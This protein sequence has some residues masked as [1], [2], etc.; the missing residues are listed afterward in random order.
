MTNPSSF[1][2]I[3]LDIGGTKTSVVFSTTW[4]KNGET[5]NLVTQGANLQIHGATHVAGL[6][7]S[8]VARIRHQFD[9]EM[10]AVVVAGIAGAGRADDHLEV[11]QLFR[12]ALYRND[13]IMVCSDAF[14]AL[15]G[16]FS[17]GSGVIIIAGTGSGVYALDK[18]RK[19]RRAGGWGPHLG[20][21]G[22]GTSIG[23]NAL[24]SVARAF[25]GGQPTELT[26][27][28]AEHFGIYD[29]SDLI[30]IVYREGFYPATCAPLVIQSAE[31]GDAV[32]SEMVLMEIK[33]LADESS[34]VMDDSI[35]S[36]FVLMGGLSENRWFAEQLIAAVVKNGPSW[37]RVEPDRGPEMGALSLTE[38]LTSKS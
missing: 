5:E 8:V 10:N 14:I 31:G 6:I 26:A 32:S 17:G 1:L 19:L 4:L 20:D 34:L 35:D 22:S 24:R 15:E 29:R 13:R 16:A 23:L 9:P 36:R 33:K 28:F 12:Q 30:R 27:L 37:R 11:E 38:Q 2:R 3:G 18:D 21:P 7:A 25:D